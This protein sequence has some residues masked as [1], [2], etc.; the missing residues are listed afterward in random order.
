MTWPTARSKNTL[1]KSLYTNSIRQSAQPL[2]LLCCSRSDPGSL[3]IH[4]P[5]QYHCALDGKES[6]ASPVLQNPGPYSEQLRSGNSSTLLLSSLDI[7]YHASLNLSFVSMTRPS[8]RPARLN[9][10]SGVRTVPPSFSLISGRDTADFFSTASH[11]V[12]NLLA[13]W[14][15]RIPSQVSFLLISTFHTA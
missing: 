9:P 1:S 7:S 13:S 4:C 3:P 8:L 10:T 11:S 5:Y 14:L 6:L 15:Y 12:T 2:S